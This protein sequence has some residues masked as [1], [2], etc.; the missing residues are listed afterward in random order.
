MRS[1][2][3]TFTFV[4]IAASLVSAQGVSPASEGKT[5][6]QVYKNIVA[7]KGTPANEL[8]QSMHLMKGAI[9]VDCTYCHIEREWEKDVK[10]KPVAR[11]MIT[12][13]MDINT[14]Q[15][16]GRQVVTCYTCHNGRPIPRDKPVFPVFEPKLPDTPALP[17][18]DAV[19]SKYVD[20][21]GGAQAIQKVTSRTIT[22]TQVHSHR[23]RRSRADARRDGAVPQ[24]AEPVAHGL[25]DGGVHDLARLRRHDRVVAGSERP[26][27]RRGRA[28]HRACEARRRRARSAQLQAAGTRE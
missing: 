3:A 14:R 23:P 9:G 13:M 28:R 10:A 4:L 7:L 6:E 24:G 27:G 11:Q 25:Q 26:R 20:A 16:G 5:A 18:V 19:L 22:G 2:C 15:F 17:T 1:P 8:N 21:L 12:M